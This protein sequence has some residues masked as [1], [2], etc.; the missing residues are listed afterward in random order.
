MDQALRSGGGRGAAGGSQPASALIDGEIVVENGSGASD[1]SALQAALS[2]GRKTG[3]QFYAFDLLYL[4]GWDL[5]D[6]P[7]AARKDALEGCSRV[8]GGAA[9]LGPFRER[10]RHGAPP[11][12]SPQLEGIVSKKRDAPYRSGT[13]KDWVKSKCAHRQEFVVA[14]YVPS[15]TSRKA[16]GSLVLG[17]YDGGRLVHVAGSEP[18]IPRPSPRISTAGSKTSASTRARSPNA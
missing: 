3:F 17:Y 11:R 18:A 2:E 6:S 4:D 10:R 13:R 7:L 15:S 9:L 16:I 5:R 12:L 8:R 14:G 1:F